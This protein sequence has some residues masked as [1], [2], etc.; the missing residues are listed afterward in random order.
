EIGEKFRFIRG[1]DDGYYPIGLNEGSWINK[2][3]QKVYNSGNQFIDEY[4]G[5]APG[6]Y[7]VDTNKI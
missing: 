1:R 2:E 7:E 6:L 4:D 5:S 3:H